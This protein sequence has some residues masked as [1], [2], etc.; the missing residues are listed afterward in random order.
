[1]I[2]ATSKSNAITSRLERFRRL[3]GERLHGFIINGARRY[4][5]NDLTTKLLPSM[6][7]QG[8]VSL[9]VVPEDRILLSVTVGQL[10]AHL[11]GDLA[12][13]EQF[14]DRL[15]ENCMV[16]GLGLDEGTLYFG[17]KDN[18]AVIVRGDRPDIQ[19][20]ALQTPTACMVLTKGIRPIEYVQYEAELEEVPIVVVQSDTLTTMDLL[21]SV[22]DKAR[23]DHAAKLER[24]KELITEHVDIEALYA[25]LG[26]AA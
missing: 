6:S 14:T 7:S 9:G 20:A 11:G 1:M 19:M 24:Y 17:L 25:G 10:A 21:N 8:L 18:K 2:V 23:F 4:Q 13:G 12:I 16:G 3:F 22:Q 5:G 15:V 26:I